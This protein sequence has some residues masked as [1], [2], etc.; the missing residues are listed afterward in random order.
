MFN[1]TLKLNFC[2]CVKGLIVSDFKLWHM[3]TSCFPIRNV[4][5]KMKRLAL[6]GIQFLCN[7][8]DICK[9]TKYVEV[10]TNTNIDKQKQC[11]KSC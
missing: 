8:I 3:R 7:C 4:A 2:H 5:V 9:I 1:H 6:A 11:L 10:L